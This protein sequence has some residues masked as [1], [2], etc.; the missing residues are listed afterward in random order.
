MTNKG[1]R[2]YDTSSLLIRMDDIFKEPFVISSIS[3]AEL[4]NIKSSNN[5]DYDIKSNARRLLHL[6]DE[7]SENY[8]TVIYKETMITP[9]AI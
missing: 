6:L 4:E 2:F 3:L 9:L 1:I 7:N 5:K 8:T